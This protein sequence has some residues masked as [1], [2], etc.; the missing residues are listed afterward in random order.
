MQNITATTNNE[1]IPQ[2]LSTSQKIGKH[3]KATHY[4]LGI[5]GK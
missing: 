2:H 4:K 3:L 1:N 5:D